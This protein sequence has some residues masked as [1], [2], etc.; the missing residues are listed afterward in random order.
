M[1]LK[2]CAIATLALLVPALPG[3]DSAGKEVL[4]PAQR[5]A[6][7]GVVR[8][9]LLKNPKILRQAIERLQAV[10]E[11]ERKQRAVDAIS[12]NRPALANDPESP[13]GGNPNGDVTVVE[14]FDYR[15][16]YCK[17]V[18]PTLQ[19]LAER[20]PKVRIVYKEFPILGPDSVY[21]ARAALAAHRRNQYVPFHIGMMTSPENGKAAVKSTAEKLGFDEKFFKEIENPA[22][23]KMIEKNIRLAQVMDIGGTPAF[24]VGDQLVPGA[25]DI[26]SL[27][28]MVKKE[29]ARLGSGES[30]PAAAP[31]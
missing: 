16:G 28:E 14:F 17:K 11:A 21:A 4:T 18:A 15:C 22:F 29:R 9:Y 7:E 27:T 12:S 24:V 2:Y 20:D 5:E 13:V 6:M 10:E 23:D 26:D 31:K 1:F 8:D 30:K 25:I 19:A 3:Q